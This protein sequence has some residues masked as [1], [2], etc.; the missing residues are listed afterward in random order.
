MKKQLKKLRKQLI[1]DWGKKCPDFN[2]NC[3]VCKVH[4]ALEILEHGY[5]IG[6]KIYK[7]ARPHKKRK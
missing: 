3:C 6:V 5:V 1:K 4:L 2:I 7:Q